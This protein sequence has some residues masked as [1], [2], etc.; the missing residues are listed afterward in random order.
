MGRVVVMGSVNM[1]L[2]VQVARLPRPG[3]TVLGDRLTRAHGGKGA[4]QAVAAA[5]LGAQVRFIGRVGRDAFGDELLAGLREDGV[6]VAGVSVD[7][8]E[9]S[10]AALIVVERGGDN[11]ITVAPGANSRVGDDEVAQLRDG[12]RPDDIVLMQLEVPQVAVDAA[13]AVAR[14]AG[15]R[16]ILNAA[17]YS[18]QDLPRVDVLIV[19]ETERRSLGEWARADTLVVTL[20]ASGADVVENGRTAHVDSPGRQVGRRHWRR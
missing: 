10:G 3:E 8:A 19:N 17:P 12:L 2:V 15:A 1:D 6:D 9:P 7:D 13:I 20:G 16:V 11:E 14:D 5:R 4:N 18:G